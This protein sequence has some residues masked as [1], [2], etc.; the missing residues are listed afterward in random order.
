VAFLLAMALLS[1]IAG[2][3]SEEWFAVHRP[4]SFMDYWYLAWPI[5]VFCTLM[6]FLL[7]GEGGVISFLAG[8]KLALGSSLKRGLLVAGLLLAALIP[9]H[10]YGRYF[11]ETFGNFAI[12]EAGEP[13]RLGFR[14]LTAGLGMN[15]GIPL[16]VVGGALTAMIPRGV[17][18]RKRLLALIVPLLFI[19]SVWGVGKSFANYCQKV[20]E[21]DKA[22]LDEAAS[23]IKQ[24]KAPSPRMA[25]LLKDA[26]KEKGTEVKFRDPLHYPSP[27]EVDLIP[28]NLARLNEYL[29]TLEGKWTA[30]TDQAMYAR[31]MIAS[32]YWLVEDFRDI[33]LDN[34]LKRGSILNSMLLL[35]SLIH[36]PTTARNIRILDDLS[37]EGKF[38][39]K[40]KACLRMAGAWAAM[41]EPE[42]AKKFY[43]CAQKSLAEKELEGFTISEKPAFI[44]GKLTGRIRGEVTKRGRLGIFYLREEKDFG[45][46]RTSLGP[47]RIKAAMDLG[48]DGSFLFDNLPEGRYYLGLLLREDVQGPFDIRGGGIFSVGWDNPTVKTGEIRVTQSSSVESPDKK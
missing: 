22:S 35:N 14:R 19:L 27:K 38:I 43:Q 34:S 8:R 7:V 40:G 5:H 1:P 47:A 42:K 12:G 6:L 17:A 13:T 23:L 15:F 9:V 30:F 46:G 48:E 41:G 31:Q 28:E 18:S 29:K 16:A 39:V 36:S 2:M 32:R 10:L 44:Q 3:F 26:Q 25:L 45:A 4:G 37:D 11:Y 33:L 20:W 24:P 21:M